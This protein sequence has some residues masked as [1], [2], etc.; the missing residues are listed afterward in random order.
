MGLSPMMQHYLQT[1]EKYKDCLLFY[2]L[3]D[4]YEMFFEDA[5]TASKALDLTLTGRD[6]GLEERAPMCGV[7]HHAVTSYVSRLIESGYKVAICEQLEDPA[8]AKGMVER[9]V[10][11][12]ITPGTVIEEDLL[13]ESKNNYIV[14]IFA[15][16]NLVGYAYSDITTGKFMA[17][18][19]NGA[20]CINELYDFLLKLSPSEILCNSFLCVAISKWPA[21]CLELLPKFSAYYDWAFQ[22]QTATKALKKQFQ[23]NSFEAFEIAGK[24]HIIAAAGA[25]VQYFEETQFK[26]LSHINKIQYVSDAKYMRLDANTFRNL[27]IL[28]TMHENK[29]QGSLL[30]L[31]DRTETSMGARMLTEWLT[32]PLNVREEIELRL[33][34]VEE[35]VEERILRETLSE[36]LGK[37]KDVER[38]ATKISYGNLLPRDCVALSRS[39]A[40]LPRIKE[41]L[42]ARSSELLQRIDSGIRVYPE[43]C[44]LLDSAISEDYLGV[45]KD[46]GFIREGYSKEL[47][48]MKYVAKN[49]KGWLAE[50][51]AKERERT[52]IKNL[53]VG[54]N[55]VFGYYIEV[56]KSYLSLAPA[57]YIRKQTLANAERYI[58]P[59]LKE[60]E[61]EILKAE[62]NSIRLE[63]KLYQEIL[64]KLLSYVPDLQSTS[65]NLAK[66]DCLLSFAVVSVKNRYVKPLINDFGGETIVADGRHPVVET[67]MKPGAFVPNDAFLDSGEDNMMIITGPNMAGKSTYMRQVALIVLMA[68]VGCFVPAKRAEI[69]LTDRIFTRVGASDNL[70][71]DQST[72]MVEMVEVANI[73]NN[74]TENSLLILD[75]VGRGTST[76]DGL[77]IAWAVVEYLSEH[78][79][80]KTL[81]AT[82]YHELTELEG[83]LPG[84]KN[85]KITVKETGGGILFLRKIARGGANRSFGIEVAALAGLPKSVV[86][87][88]KQILKRLEDADI[89]R[90]NG[91]VQLGFMLQEEAAA[92]ESPE[93]ENGA[94]LQICDELEKLDPNEL[95]PIEALQKIAAWKGM[96]S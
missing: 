12:V 10:V 27:E 1:K 54:Y 50:F 77:S 75:E 76:F 70:A 21:N 25:L 45:I 2:R 90:A 85:Y 5:V 59:E 36:L 17:G 16:K 38:L 86:A 20:G 23:V 7:P 56:T 18:E 13:D 71:F 37:I 33:D 81:F 8:L 53:K 92:A 48:E 14:S 22:G 55:K 42:A 94:Y 68:H 69:A 83:I 84:V 46:G 44:K 28:A 63:T 30:W 66:L 11:R 61:D 34:A 73:L 43:I 15:D 49:G 62:E 96:L 88:S 26:L 40:Q 74:A 57:E 72:F 24:K 51:E 52:G 41:L 65:Q 89:N 78:V 39:L 32:K 58:T 91:K 82:H 35:L 4:F 9:G 79:R 47:D 29:R 64:A 67:Y 95:S 60:M 3:G 6:C 31:L 80:A 93:G 19:F 87:R